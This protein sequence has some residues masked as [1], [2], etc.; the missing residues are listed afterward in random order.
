MAVPSIF[1]V[2]PNGKTKDA[3]WSWTPNSST[4]VFLFNGSEAA[5]D[6][7]ENPN[8]ATFAI[9]GIDSL[10]PALAYVV[11]VIIALFVYLF[12]AYP[13]YLMT[14]ASTLP[15]VVKALIKLLGIIDTIIFNGLE[16][17]VPCW[18]V[19]FPA[20]TALNKPKW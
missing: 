8:K 13:I 11:T 1:T 10:K 14:I 18:T 7:V 9:Y 19:I 2:I 15:F 12:V 17:A 20:S 4:V 3:I 16:P 6:D 5:D